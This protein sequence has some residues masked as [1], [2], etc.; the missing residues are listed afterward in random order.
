MSPEIIQK[1]QTFLFSSKKEM[2]DARLP[3]NVQQ[4]ILRLR[5]VYTYW[6]QKP[7]LTDRA[8]VSFMQE[9]YKIGHAVAYEDLRLIKICLGNLNQCTTDYFRWVFLSRAEEAFQMA[10]DNNDPKAFAAALATFGKYTRLD[11]ADGNVPDYSQIVPQQ[12]TITSDP[13]AAGFKRI[14]D[15]EVKIKKMLSRYITDAERPQYVEAEEVPTAKS[16]PR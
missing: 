1:T 6:L 9:T 8:V 2:D 15:L 4:H 14:P 11:Q 13:E 5:A 7:Q 12:F 3:E 16:S 10:R